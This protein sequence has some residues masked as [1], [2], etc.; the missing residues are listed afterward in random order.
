MLWWINVVLLLGGDVTGWLTGLN[1]IPALEAGVTYFEA[2]LKV[3]EVFVSNDIAIDVTVAVF[4]ALTI[5][6]VV[7]LAFEVQEA[8]EVTQG[9]FLKSIFEMAHELLTGEEIIDALEFDSF[10]SVEFSV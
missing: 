8:I 6:F 10:A 2:L 1:E 3:V 4:G 5:A 7:A 9:T